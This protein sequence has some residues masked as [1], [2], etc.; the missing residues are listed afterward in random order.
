MLAIPVLVNGSLY[1]QIM[2]YLIATC[3]EEPQ[4]RNRG[5]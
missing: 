3:S 2:S 1:L 4:V 5:T